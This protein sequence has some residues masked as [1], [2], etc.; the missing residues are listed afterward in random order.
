MLSCYLQ[1]NTNLHCLPEIKTINTLVFTNTG[2]QCIPNYGNV[3]ISS[4]DHTNLPICNLFNAIICDFYYNITGHVFFDINQNCFVDLGEASIQ[5]L[6]INVFQGG[7]LIQ[8]GYTSHTGLFSLDTELGTYDYTLDTVEAP[9]FIACP[10]GGFH[11]SV[12][13][14]SDSLDYGMDFGLQ[15]KPGFDIGVV[16]VVQNLPRFSPGDTSIVITKAGDITKLYNL[17]CSSG[18]SGTVVIDYSGPVQ[19]AGNFPGSLIPNVTPNTLT[20]NISDFGNN[21]LS[22]DFKFFMYT[23]T[24]TTLGQ[25]VCFNVTVTPSISGDNNT[26]N[27]SLS[28]CFAVVNSFDPNNKE[29]N[30]IGDILQ[31]QEWLTYTINFQNTGNAPAQHIVITDTLDA[32]IQEATFAYLGSSHDPFIQVNGNVVIFSFPNINLP[33]STNNEPNS[34]GY[35]QYKVKIDAGL[36]IGATI[37][38]TAAIYFDFNAPVITNT[39]L[40]T[41]VAPNGINEISNNF[42]TVYPNPS[43]EKITIRSTSTGL[44]KLILTDVAGR[45]VYKNEFTGNEFNFYVNEFASGMYFLNLESDGKSEVLKIVVR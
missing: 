6:K 25:Q 40:N 3:Q 27:N 19:F 24:T 8:Q 9:Y 34:H 33:D 41:V 16:T 20:Y 45:I 17:N 43:S 2:I 39:T 23:D 28:H 15:C 22:S 1:D 4:P 32:N 35:V 13:T 38:N 30:P 12:L 31:G 7:N 21:N 29:V 18:I 11:N 37:E 10:S 26:A 36:P 42:F 5:G 14:A 44:H